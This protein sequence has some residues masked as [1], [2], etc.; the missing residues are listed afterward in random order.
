M[1]RLYWHLLRKAVVWKRGCACVLTVLFIPV[2]P[3]YA[4]DITE[5]QVYE[6]N[7]VY[8]IKVVA[9]IDAPVEYVHKA[10]TDFDH[11]YRLNP[12]IIESQLL[13]SP[14]DAVVRVK[15]RISDCIFIFCMEIDRVEDVY[16]F[17]G[18]GLRTVIIPALSSFRS[19]KA[20]WQIEGRKERSRIIYEAQM[21]PDFVIIP[22]FGSPFVKSL[23]RKGTATSLNRIECVAKIQEELDWDA[24]LQITGI[25]DNAGCQP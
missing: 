21:E 8:Y 13:P 20:D 19:G 7:G 11:L 16:K 12:S 6:N 3:L 18:Y 1:F 9:E 15:T 2:L 4:L 10:L 5:L 17:P 14:N 22:V 24:H 23:L 25:N